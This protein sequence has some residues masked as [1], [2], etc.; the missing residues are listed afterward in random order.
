MPYS[1]EGST[2]RD[3]APVIGLTSSDRQAFTALFEAL[4]DDLVRFVQRR[5][6][7]PLVEDVVAEVFLVAWRR[8]SDVPD[9]VA[10][11]RP[12]LF[13]VARRTL[14][15]AHR[16]RRRAAALALRVSTQPRAADDEEPAAVV[17][18][19]DLARAFA[20]LSPRDQE[21]LALVAW[22]GLTPT[23]AAQILDVSVSAFSV[24]L[25]RARRR[26][27]AHLDHRPTPGDP[28]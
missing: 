6:D 14:A 11:A 26:L 20:Q 23:E 16:G 8:F 2:G 3:V 21:A 17:H 13:A 24:R 18:R 10:H 25:S 19:V 7:E 4:Y 28:S 9:G 12:W 27:R 1:T 5:V 22:D 15:N